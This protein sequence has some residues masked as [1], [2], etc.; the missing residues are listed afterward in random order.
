MFSCQKATQAEGPEERWR[1]NSSGCRRGKDGEL[2]KWKCEDWEKLE[3]WKWNAFKSEKLWK[4]WQRRSIDHA[5]K[6]GKSPTRWI[7]ELLNDNICDH[8]SVWE[9][10][11]FHLRPVLWINNMASLKGFAP[12]RRSGSVTHAEKFRKSKSFQEISKADSQKY[13]HTFQANSADHTWEIQ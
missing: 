13:C 9:S 6:L 12:F 8:Y 3:K 7:T 5:H 10:L 2:G 11:L 1:H 4:V